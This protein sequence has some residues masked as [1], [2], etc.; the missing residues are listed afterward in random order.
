M[1]M[2]GGQKRETEEKYTQA[3]R[4]ENWRRETTWRTYA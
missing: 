1:W 3:F 4:G 2:G